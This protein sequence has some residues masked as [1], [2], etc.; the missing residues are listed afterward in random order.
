MVIDDHQDHELFQ[1]IH[2]LNH[3][4]MIYLLILMNQLNMV[5][6]LAMILDNP[7]QLLLI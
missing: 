4:L 2:E 7:I 6:I 1:L 3:E 5:I